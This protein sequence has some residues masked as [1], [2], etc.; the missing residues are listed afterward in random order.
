M[1]LKLVHK[2]GKKYFQTDPMKP[3]LPRYQN[4]IM[5]QQKMNF[6]DECRCKNPQ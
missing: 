2:I 3:I 4:W 6:P 1:L 5:T